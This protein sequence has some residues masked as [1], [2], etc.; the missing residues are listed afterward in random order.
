MKTSALL[1]NVG[2]VAV[3][4]QHLYLLPLN[5]QAF[6]DS[7]KALRVQSGRA[8]HERSSLVGGAQPTPQHR[9][10][11]PE[12]PTSLGICHLSIE[13]ES[14]VILPC[15]TNPYLCLINSNVA[16]LELTDLLLDDRGCQ[17]LNIANENVR[18]SDPY[19][20]LQR[21]HRRRCQGDKSYSQSRHI[22]LN[23]GLG[24]V[25]KGWHVLSGQ[26]KSD[27]QPEEIQRF[28][29]FDGTQCWS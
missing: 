3:A 10:V 7:L 9:R 1:E 6:L 14:F 12:V 4:G 13:R 2:P 29:K 5:A 26:E 28:P 16:D 27:L 21:L 8:E 11:W 25:G 18:L 17:R 23:L 20:L 15:Q 19:L 22:S 24:L